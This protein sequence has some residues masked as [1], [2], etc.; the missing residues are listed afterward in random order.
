MC[1]CFKKQKKRFKSKIFLAAPLRNTLQVSSKPVSH[2]IGFKT[3]NIVRIPDWLSAVYLWLIT[4]GKGCQSSLPVTDVRC[5]NGAALKEGSVIFICLGRS[6]HDW[7]L[8][9]PLTLQPQSSCSWPAQTPDESIPPPR[10]ARQ[11]DVTKYRNIGIKL[12][13]RPGTDMSIHLIRGCCKQLF[14]SK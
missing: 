3:G 8:M 11:A 7:P 4:D 10:P 6:P 9:W 14:W 12:S 13:S 1:D 2:S 5:V